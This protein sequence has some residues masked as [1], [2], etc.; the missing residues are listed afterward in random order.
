[1]EC[2]HC[3]STHF[4]R[5]AAHEK[6]EFLRCCHCS[7][8]FQNPIPNSKEIELFYNSYYSSVHQSSPSENSRRSKAYKLDLSFI[9][10]AVRD[11]GLDHFC[12]TSCFDF[13]ASGGQFLYEIG[14]FVTYRR[15]WDYGTEAKCELMR[16]DYYEDP[17]A[18]TG[19]G[20]DLLVLRGV[21]EH[22]VEP[23]ETISKV[24]SSKQPRSILI[25]A[26]P[27]GSSV[28]Y[29]IYRDKWRM[30]LPTEH[31]WQFSCH[32][33]VEMLASKGFV[34]TDIAFQ[35]LDSPYANQLQDCIEV[36][37]MC[38]LRNSQEYIQCTKSPP[39]FDSMITLF[40]VQREVLV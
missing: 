34:T 26:T 5:Y 15:G 23:Y 21:I 40:A 2:Y 10:K 4:S 24:I 16:K 18:E 12:I 30:H 8:I 3:G 33:F 1:M 13:G 38:R 28:A 22:L 37:D 25:S 6:C 7:L 32:H 20:Y 39:Y 14:N 29:N 35:Y 11:I 19:E 9:E 36:Y 27:N 17:F 31:I